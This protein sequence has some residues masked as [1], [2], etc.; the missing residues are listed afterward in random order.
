MMAF[1]FVKVSIFLGG[2]SLQS[3]NLL[4]CLADQEAMMVTFEPSFNVA[5]VT[6]GQT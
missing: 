2:E 5:L 6:E 4:I 3:C 1:I